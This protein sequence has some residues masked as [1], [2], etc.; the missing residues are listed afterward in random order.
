M[1]CLYINKLRKVLKKHSYKRELFGGKMKQANTTRGGEH[2]DKIIF[3]DNNLFLLS[4]F[5]GVML[6]GIFFNKRSCVH[7]AYVNRGRRTLKTFIYLF[8]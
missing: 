7:K 1:K 8:A 2:F 3:N 6:E 5:S 4:V